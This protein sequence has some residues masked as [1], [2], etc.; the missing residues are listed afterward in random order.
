V[1][2]FQVQEAG[3]EV[4]HPVRATLRN[5]AT[6]KEETVRAQYLIGADGAASSI[7][8]QMK[9]PFDGLGTD[10]YWAIIDCQ[11]KTD[12]PHLFGMS[13]ITSEHG[14]CIVIPR[15]EGFTR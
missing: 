3:A 14:G 7:R 4:T 6:G 5:V 9:V 2:E 10:I 15:E 12:Y 13:M 1:K 8:E 11:F